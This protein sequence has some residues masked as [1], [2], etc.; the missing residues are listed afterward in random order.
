[1]PGMGAGGPVIPPGAAVRP[2]SEFTQVLQG[3]KGAPQAPANPAGSAPRM[4]GAAAAGQKKKP[5]ILP[6]VIIIN[7]VVLAAI[8]LVLYF[9]LRG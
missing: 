9:L 8:A 5:S 4:A 1:M 7:V 2:P 3:F 6:L